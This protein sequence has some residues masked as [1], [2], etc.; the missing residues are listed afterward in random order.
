MSVAT[1]FS[2]ARRSAAKAKAYRGCRA[3]SPVERTIGYASFTQEIKDRL[4]FFVEASLGN[5]ETDTEGGFTNFQYTCIQPDNAYIQP[6]QQGGS[7]ALLNFVT[8][9]AGA[10]PVSGHFGAPLPG[11]PAGLPGGVPFIKNWENQIDQGNITS[12]DL[13][14]RRRRVRRRVWRFDVDLGRLLPVGQIRTRAAR[15]RPRI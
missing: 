5:P 15:A 7:S 3:G 10:F 2:R 11:F 6:S 4:G 13:E 12:T 1:A 9:N 8:A 14:P